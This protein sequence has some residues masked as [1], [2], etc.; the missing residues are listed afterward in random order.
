M[1]AITN[2]IAY[3]TNHGDAPAAPTNNIVLQSLS[4]AL[5]K[6][7]PE[8]VPAQADSLVLKHFSIALRKRFPN[9]E[10]YASPKIMQAMSL[11]YYGWK[12]LTEAVPELVPTPPMAIAI[13]HK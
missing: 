7:W 9:G 5:R 8:P 4:I 13:H 10:P 1:S 3:H 12:Y 6:R 11:G 2:N